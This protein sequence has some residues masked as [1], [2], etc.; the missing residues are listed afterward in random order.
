MEWAKE[1]DGEAEEIAKNAAQFV[2]DNVL[3]EHIYCY[4]VQLLKVIFVCKHCTYIIH[5][6]DVKPSVI[7]TIVHTLY[8]VMCV[9][10]SLVC[11]LLC[12]LL[13]S[14]EVHRSHKCMD[15]ISGMPTSRGRHKTTYYKQLYTC[16]TL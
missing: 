2:R 10:L 6:Y 1:N 9:M 7:I 4:M 12:S 13:L 11:M 3:P 15:V 5:V 8:T 14:K 16:M